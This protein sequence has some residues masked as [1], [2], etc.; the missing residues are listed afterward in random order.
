MNVSGVQAIISEALGLTQPV[1][2][3]DGN[4]VVNVV[5]V[6]MGINNALGLGC[7]AQ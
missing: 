2:D 4:G 7:T 1:H 3:L 5:D 6:L